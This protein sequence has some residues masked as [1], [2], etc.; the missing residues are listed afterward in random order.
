MDG[1]YLIKKEVKIKDMVDALVSPNGDATIDVVVAERK[2]KSTQ[3]TLH[4]HVDTVSHQKHTDDFTFGGHIKTTERR[5]VAVIKRNPKG[6]DFGLLTLIF[7]ENPR[8]SL[9]KG[10][11]KSPKEK[12]S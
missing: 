4:L 5:Y 11:S 8:F 10:G 12:K 7:R 6:N 9:I 2:H 1:Q 3:H